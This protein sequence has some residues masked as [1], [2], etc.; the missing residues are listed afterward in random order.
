MA[1]VQD[2]LVNSSDE[3]IIEKEDFKIGAS[4]EQHIRHIIMSEKGWWKFAPL[5]GFGVLHRLNAPLTIA[6]RNDVKREMKIQL[7]LDGMTVHSID[8]ASWQNL[9]VDATY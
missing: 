4:T 2:I 1:E 7:E 9:K 6:V 3:L 5:V 8:V